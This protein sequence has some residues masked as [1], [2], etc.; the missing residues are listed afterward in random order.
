MNKLVVFLLPT[1]WDASPSQPPPPALHLP[2]FI[3]AP[4]WREALSEQKCLDQRT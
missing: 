2:V 1:G 4:G 3:P